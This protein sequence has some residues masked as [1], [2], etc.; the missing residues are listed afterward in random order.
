MHAVTETCQVTKLCRHLFCTVSVNQGKIRG[1]RNTRD[2]LVS[3]IFPW[4]NAT[5]A[6]AQ[7]VAAHVSVRFGRHAAAELPPV[8]VLRPVVRLGLAENPH[9][10]LQVEAQG[11]AAGLPARRHLS[12]EPA[13]EAAAATVTTVVG[14][15]GGTLGAWR[16]SCARDAPIPVPPL[17]SHLCRRPSACA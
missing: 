9:E 8:S 16:V 6:Q 1:T 13:A 5:R 11:P 14:D 2:K 3:R 7:Q 12:E 15:R 10:P 17:R 4:V